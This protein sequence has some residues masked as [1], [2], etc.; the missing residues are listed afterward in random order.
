ME[1]SVIE[2]DPEK[3]RAH[4]ASLEIKESADEPPDDELQISRN[5]DPN[6]PLF[7][8]VVAF[9]GTLSNFTRKSAFALTL[10]LGGI[11][12]KTI[13]KETDILVIGNED[14][15]NLKTGKKSLKLRQAEALRSEGSGVRIMSES[16]FL[17]MI[18]NEDGERAYI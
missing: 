8:L 10:T 5:M 18:D 1:C 14:A 12:K 17:I 7:N 6:S 16:E 13:S 4:Q 15:V 9:T 11:P 3:I 2:H